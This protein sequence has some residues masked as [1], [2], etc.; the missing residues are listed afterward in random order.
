MAAFA[1]GWRRE[2]KRFDKP[3]VSWVAGTTGELVQVQILSPVNRAA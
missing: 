3:T 1:K 2:G